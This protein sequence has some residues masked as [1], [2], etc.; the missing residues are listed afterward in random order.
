MDRGRTKKGCD[1]WGL[2]KLWFEKELGIELPDFD[3]S[4]NDR[5]LVAET[6]D[7][8]RHEP[9]WEP[10]DRPK[11]GDVVAMSTNPHHPGMVNHVGVYLGRYKILHTTEKTGAMIIPSTNLMWSKRI[12]G[13]Y[14]W[15]G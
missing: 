10:V 6:I 14:R 7:S 9:V 11:K 3:V 12:V 2:V 15:V 1:C 13:Y 8:G 4:A 5:E